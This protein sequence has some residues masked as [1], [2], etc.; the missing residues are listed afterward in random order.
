MSREELIKELG[1]KMPAL[2]R[3]LPD[4]I[5]FIADFIIKDR[6]RIVDPIKKH[7][8][9]IIKLMG[10]LSWDDDDALYGSINETLKNAGVL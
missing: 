9:L 7:K 3:H 1:L 4:H 8:D 6:K 2:D 5:Q 10:S